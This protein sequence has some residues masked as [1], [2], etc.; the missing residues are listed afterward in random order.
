MK[1]ITTEFFFSTSRPASIPSVLASRIAVEAMEQDIDLSAL[2]KDARQI[3]IVRYMTLVGLSI[4]AYDFLLTFGDEVAYMW[5]SKSRAS[6]TL[7]ILFAYSR[8]G[9]LVGTVLFLSAIV[10]PVEGIDENWLIR[11]NSRHRCIGS[12]VAIVLIDAPVFMFGD[13]LIVFILASAWQWRKDITR[14]LLAGTL[15]SAGGS[16]VFTCLYVRRMLSGHLIQFQSIGSIRACVVS[17]IPS[18][19]LRTFIFYAAMDLYMQVLFVLN[20]LSR[21]RGASERL[22]D[23]LVKDGLVV[24]LISSAM[25]IS[26][27]VVISNAPTPIGLVYPEVMIMIVSTATS[28]LYLRFCSTKLKLQYRQSDLELH[29]LQ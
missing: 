15:I 16:I 1:L 25:R 3:L 4:W 12:V 13:G 22:M 9:M 23:I 18:E 28:R 20:A 21:P 19:Y 11:L 6:N 17:T 7:R 26:N 2:T 29:L 8:Y 5:S 14:M 27:L 10:M 24:L